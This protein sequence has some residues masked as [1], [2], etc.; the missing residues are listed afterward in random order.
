MAAGLVCAER[1]LLAASQ[2]VRSVESWKWYRASA[3]ASKGEGQFLVASRST[4]RSDAKNL[5]GLAG[6]AHN[7]A[8]VADVAPVAHALFTR[9]SGCGR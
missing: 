4:T 3:R 8:G 2:L 5:S 6:G 1:Q 9:P 7:M